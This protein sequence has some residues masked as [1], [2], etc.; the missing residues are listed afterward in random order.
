MCGPEHASLARATCAHAGLGAAM[1]PPKTYSR[2]YSE[3]DA[4]A[5]QSPGSRNVR[6]AMAP[7]SPCIR[8][9]H[10]PERPPCLSRST[11]FQ[12]SSS[13]TAGFM[14][15]FRWYSLQTRRRTLPAGS[16]VCDPFERER[17]PGSLSERHLYI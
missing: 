4:C 14:R 13:L 15:T 11:F 5:K 3:A 7:H 6:A 12:S 17:S 2:G 10:P 1:I 8:T 9:S 16:N